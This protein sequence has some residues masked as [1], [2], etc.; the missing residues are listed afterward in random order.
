MSAL[1]VPEH[2]ACQHTVSQSQLH[3]PGK[4]GVSISTPSVEVRWRE[5]CMLQ[6]DH[7]IHYSGQA[8]IGTKGCL[9]LELSILRMEATW[10]SQLLEIP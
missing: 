2:R 5:G 8:W 1:Q 3:G 4:D 6:D 7:L 9:T 10:V